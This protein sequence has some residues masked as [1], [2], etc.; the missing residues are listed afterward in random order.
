MT[1]AVFFFLF[2]ISAFTLE[3]Q[4]RVM[5]PGTTLQQAAVVK[6][7]PLI[8]PETEYNFGQIPQGKPVTHVFKL[9]N[10][11][12][13]PIVLT[14]VHASCGC[15]TPVWSRD[16]I[17][18]GDSSKI[19]VGFNAAAE[20]PFMKPIMITYNDNQSKQ[21]IIRGEVWKTPSQSAP[22]NEL[23]NQLNKKQ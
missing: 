19:T 15:T 4:E 6:S 1:R 16:T 9:E 21:I 12:K 5:A 7:D 17:P 11:G 3:A 8:M 14:N 13:E 23:I 2:I 18:A 10:N 20:G 22:E